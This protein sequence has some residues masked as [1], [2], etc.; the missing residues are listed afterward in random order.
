[1]N[2]LAL[3]GLKVLDSLHLI[4]P[5]SPIFYST[6]PKETD[7]SKKQ[8]AAAGCSFSLLRQVV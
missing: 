1:M 6:T 5:E 8:K 2:Y 7:G 4:P 3:L